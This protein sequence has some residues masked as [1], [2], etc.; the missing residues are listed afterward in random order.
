MGLEGKQQ[1]VIVILEDSG[2]RCQTRFSVKRKCSLVGTES[3]AHGGR[4]KRGEAL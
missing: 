4:M 2:Q 1:N 3:G